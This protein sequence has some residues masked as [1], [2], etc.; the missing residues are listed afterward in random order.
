M[1]C[2][3]SFWRRVFDVTYR[4]ARAAEGAGDYRRAASLYAE[5]DLPEDAANALLFHATRVRTLDERLAAYQDAL[6]WLPDDHPR[7]AEVEGRMGS[8]VLEDA[9][10]RGA[11]SAEE[12]GRLED[13]ARR[14]ER[15]GRPSDAATAFELLG[16][17][18]DVARCLQDAGDVERLEKLLERTHEEESR[19]RRLRRLV[20]DYELGMEV[21]ARL[22]ARAALR[23]AVALAPDDAALADLLRRLEDRLP[24]PGTLG[25]VVDGARVSFV[26]RLPA[27]I[28]RDADVV[29][30]GASVSRRHTEIGLRGG[31]LVVRDLDSRNGTLVRGLPIA[32]ELELSGATEIGL[33]DDVQVLVTPAT[34]TSCLLEVR[35]GLDRGLRGVVGEGDLRIPALPFRV[36]FASGHATLAADPGVSLTLGTQPCALPVVLLSEDRLSLGAHTLEVC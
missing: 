14:L 1:F 27:A 29:V 15:A 25:L 26:G 9:Q 23:D 24:A 17:A 28:G 32:R 34:P 6:R 12:R 19:E 22:E 36:S 21:G 2:A 5:A 13:A 8:A 3:V 30:R 35:S 16:R 4:R 10:Q 20:Q 7:R 31:R 11:R 18:E 33:G